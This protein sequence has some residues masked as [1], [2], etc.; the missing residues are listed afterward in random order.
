MEKMLY[1]DNFEGVQSI[2]FDPPALFEIGLGVRSFKTASP[3]AKLF[4]EQA[5]IWA[6]KQGF[7]PT[8]AD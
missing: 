3:L 2:S 7:A 6:Q 8:E 5:Q 1:K 4:I